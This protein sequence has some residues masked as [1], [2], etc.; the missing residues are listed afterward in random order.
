M[1]F[2]C[3]FRAVKTFRILWAV[4]RSVHFECQWSCPIY[5]GQLIPTYRWRCGVGGRSKALHACNLIICVARNRNT[6]DMLLLLEWQAFNV[7]VAWSMLGWVIWLLWALLLPG[8]L[9]S[10]VLGALQPFPHHNNC[11]VQSYLR[12]TSTLTL[13]KVGYWP[14]GFLLYR[15]T[16]N[17]CTVIVLHLYGRSRTCKSLS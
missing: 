6:V 15:K 2:A 1:E 11:R 3:C 10:F 14:Q 12:K 7:K 13:S 4:Q 5:S 8:A 17:M 16:V 9:Y